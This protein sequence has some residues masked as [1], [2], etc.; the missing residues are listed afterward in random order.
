MRA[1]LLA[2][3]LAVCVAGSAHAQGP[4]GINEVQTNKVVS[5]ISNMFDAC[6]DI[7]VAYRPDCLSRALQR[8]GSKITNNPGYWEA[9]VALTRAAR[10]MTRLVRQYVDPNAASLRVEGYRLSAVSQDA[11]PVVRRAGE[12]IMARAQ[13]DLEML[14]PYEREAFVPIA[15]LLR[16]ERPWP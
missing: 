3:L 15:R 13:Q 11:L 2:F 14:A 10:A 8:G 6:R 9:H 12:D 7:D 5:A 16:E 4:S 1:L